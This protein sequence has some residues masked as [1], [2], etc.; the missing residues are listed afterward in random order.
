[1][2]TTINLSALLFDHPFTDPEPLL[3]TSDRSVSAGEARENARHVAAQLNEHG[4]T[5]GQA[6]AIQLSKGPETVATMMGTW[7]AGCVAVPVN[8]RSPEREVE[9]VLALTGAAARYVPH[10]LA[11]AAG[12]KEYPP[13]T[14]LVMWTSGTTGPPKPI[15]HTH[16]A[17]LAF[18]DRMV[19]G[20][21][22]DRGPSE[23]RPAPN[24]IPVSL[25]LNA[26]IFNVLYG[27]RAGAAL[28]LMEQFG[29]REFADLVKR[30]EIRSTILPPAA[31]AMLNAD[32]DV[33]SL[34]PLK[35]V[36]SLTAPLSPVQ[37][38][39]FSEKFGA[40]V[41]N[42]YGQTE[43][44]E[45]I[46][47][48]AKDAKSHPEKIGAAGRPH[49]GVEVAIV[50][51]EGTAQDL[52]RAGR[53]L[54]RTETRAVGYADG[55]DL[56]DRVDK[57]G[58]IDTGDLARLDADGFIWIEG[59]LSDV[60]NRGGNKIFP[61]DVEEVLRLAESVDDVVVVGIPDD[62]LGEVPVAFL[63]GGAV[64]ADELIRL[65]RDHLAPYKVPVAFNAVTD[66]PRNASGKILRDELVASYERSVDPGGQ[67]PGD[68]PQPTPE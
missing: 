24:L 35:Y 33:A 43:I 40:F 12:G 16:A 26:G 19:T 46:G 62:R 67:D 42:G 7:L 18:L 13:G 32:P 31:I 38:R 65:C 50:D 9:R 11:T 64:D 34:D 48:T 61:G 66:L 3:F 59:R 63:T 60:I 28:V 51:D 45:V 2:S 25:A 4:V 20:L 56:H 36:R 17:Y 54:I 14:G 44:G 21:R 39:R 27:L 57:D 5:S 41:L 58:F 49:Q 29:T 52:G 23:R 47:W 10:G 53:L 37:A 30:F 68:S 55:G 1:M 22:R 8:P 6:V 15:V